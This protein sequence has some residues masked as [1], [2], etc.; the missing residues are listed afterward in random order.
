MRSHPASLL[1]LFLI[2]GSAGLAAWQAARVRATT[3]G[4]LVSAATHL[5]K[6]G[7]RIVHLGDVNHRRNVALAA[8]LASRRH[9]H[10]LKAAGFTALCLETSTRLQPFADKLAAGRIRVSDYVG[11]AT[12]LGFVP[13]G[14]TH[15]LV[16]E[17]RIIRAAAAEGLRVCLGDPDNGNEE[18]LAYQRALHDAG[19]N[20]FFG[21]FGAAGEIDRRWPQLG[22]D[23]RT[24]LDSLRAAWHRVRTDDRQ[25]AATLADLVAPGGR[26]LLVY[27]AEHGAGAHD[28]NEL[29][30]ARGVTL[31][32]INVYPDRREFDR[33]AVAAPMDPPRGDFILT[34]R[35]Y[36][37]HANPPPQHPA[38]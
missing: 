22:E 32:R 6:D 21:D 31:V 20:G 37:D 16:L 17:G 10:F 5:L 28:L 2:A 9:L 38:N 36:L 12:A 7:A 27:G 30:A 15:R 25:L 19:I 33:H 4:P 29:L 14:G 11:S 34:D 13:V 35:L 23:E 3:P 26:V 18:G 8:W 24:R 1:L